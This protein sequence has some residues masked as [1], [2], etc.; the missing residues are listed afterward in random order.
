MISPIDGSVYA[1]RSNASNEKVEATLAQ[2]V[3]AQRAWKQVP[4]AERADI[5]RRMTAWCV[6][7]ADELGK[8]LTWQIG[9]PISQS[10]GEI[11]RGFAERV[12]YMCGIAEETLQDVSVKEKQ[13]YK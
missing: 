13:G 10:P 8:E 11:R 5:C 4:V 9:R 1:D 3:I 12:E 2:A 6:A 7:R